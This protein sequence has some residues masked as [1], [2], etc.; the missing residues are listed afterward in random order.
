MNLDEFLR[1]RTTL[2]QTRPELIDL[3]E[4]NLYRSLAR[5]DPERFGAIAPSTHAEAPY[6]CHIAER[7]LDRLQ[8][9]PSLASRTL[10]SHGIRRALRALFSV[11]A[12][13]G[14]TIGLPDDV[15]PVYGKLAVDAGVR[16]I[17]WASRHGIPGEEVMA[18]LG[19]LLVCLPLKPWGHAMA[20]PEAARLAAWAR[21]DE[22]RMLLIDSAYATPPVGLAATWLHDETAV[23]LASLSKGWLIP[24]HAGV[25]IVPARFQRELRPAFAGL[26]KDERRLRVG[27]AALTD[28]ADRVV[29]VTAA[30][31]QLAER[32]DG[33][34]ATRLDLSATRCEGYFARSEHSFDRLLE[35]GV[36]AVPGAVFGATD[37]TAGCVLSS[38]GPVPE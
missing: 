16:V 33:L 24:D 27:Y 12:A 5:R 20:D 30:L 35:L 7:L 15:Y 21:A 36:L 28:H 31:G 18:R 19:A 17:S 6:R 22:R 1:R 32:L 2:R 23:L 34:A 37:P 29:H 9:A 10:V 26:P 8:L 14:T 3:S 25:C 4:L 38:L 11:L 13:Q